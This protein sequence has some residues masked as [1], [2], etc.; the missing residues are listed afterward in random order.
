MN[1]HSL[2]LT[3]VQITMAYAYWTHGKM[4]EHSVFDLHFRKNPFKGEYT[5]FAGLADCVSFIEKYKFSDADIAYLKT[6]MP[7]TT[8]PE[9][10]EYLAAID[11]KEVGFDK[12]LVKSCGMFSWISSIRFMITSPQR[13][14]K[15]QIS[16]YQP[17]YVA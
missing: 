4:N 9:F 10:F 13:S 6:A 16:T 1:F 17:K 12:S 8:K 3:C 7:A 14:P 2:N 11:T 15:C 5:I